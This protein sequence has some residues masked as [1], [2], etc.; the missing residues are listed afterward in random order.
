MRA[1]VPLILAGGSGSRMWPLSREH[2]PKQ[3]LKLMGEHSL[4]QNTARRLDAIT[5]GGECVVVCNEEYRFLVAQQLQEIHCPATILLEPDGRNTAPAVAL[6]AMH[7]RKENPVL[8][9]MPSDHIIQHGEAF[10]QVVQKAIAAAEDGTIV[11]FGI[12]P[13]EPHT[14]YGY[15]A[16]HIT[17]GM[18]IG[19]VEKFIEK[20]AQAAAEAMLA[21]GN[22]FW[23]SGIFVFKAQVFLDELKQHAP[24]IYAACEKAIQG[25]TADMDF[26]RPQKAAFLS[27]PSISIDYAVM[28][29][30]DKAV[31]IPFDS[32]WDDIGSW[33]RL[34]HVSEK[35]TQR[36][37]TVG[38]VLTED[39][40]NSYLHATSRCV[41]VLGMDAVVVIETPDAVLV[42]D[43]NKVQD[44]KKIFS[45]LKEMGRE[46]CMLHT[47]VHRPWGYYEG[48]QQDVG[49]QV[50]RLTIHPGAKISL[51][52]HERRAEHWVV[53]KGIASITKGSEEFELHPNQSTFIPAGTKHRIANM[54]DS[55]L[56]IIEVQ[57]GDYLGEDDII[58][59]DDIY[60]REV[61]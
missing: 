31:V 42:A 36:N 4:L 8:V 6:A 55:V 40:H 32:G 35:D 46:E 14:G 25:T 58:R 19:R 56:E 33:N 39:T 26:I 11:T 15:I 16:S 30:T 2:Y 22:H 3:L 17:P 37:V 18:H 43:Q 50:K 12:V 57:T 53:V 38:D 21:A 48:L 59:F 10:C 34:W 54:T 29:K 60:G 23:N 5:G 51:Q 9:V 61:A 44:I 27:S 24:E 13:T 52:Q 20:P 1:V 47:R 49:F 45:R 7:L 28:E 41:A